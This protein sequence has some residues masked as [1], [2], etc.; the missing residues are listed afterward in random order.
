MKKPLLVN[1][2]QFI[3]QRTEYHAP[4]N[5]SNP[6]CSSYIL[7]YL[8]KSF[9]HV[10][11]LCQKWVSATS[12][13]SV[14]HTKPP[15]TLLLKWKSRKKTSILKRKEKMNK[16]QCQVEHKHTSRISSGPSWKPWPHCP[17]GRCRRPSW[18]GRRAS[19]LWTPCAHHKLQNKQVW[20]IDVAGWLWR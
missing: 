18:S 2:H 19:C 4:S 15:K 11:A 7:S 12:A 16:C 17:G 8:M 10:V 6:N 5:W 20:V 14:V 9:S 1:T 13:P 3:D